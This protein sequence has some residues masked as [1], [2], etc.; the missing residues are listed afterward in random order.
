MIV[1]VIGLAAARPLLHLMASP[2]DVIDLSALY[3][4]IIFLGMPDTL[5]VSVKGAVMAA[6]VLFDIFRQS[7]KV[8][9]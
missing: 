6:A 4:R 1:G 5:R 8:P 7:R 2:D 9:A 3:L